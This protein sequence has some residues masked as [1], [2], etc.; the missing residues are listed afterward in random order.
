MQAAANP[1]A[2]HKEDPPSTECGKVVCSVTYP[3]NWAHFLK[4][5]LTLH[6]FQ[7]DR[8]TCHM[9]NNWAVEEFKS[10]FGDVI[11]SKGF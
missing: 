4:Q 3:Q 9:S 11:I 8:V 1:C 10:F 5:E 6:Y 7:Q 2:I